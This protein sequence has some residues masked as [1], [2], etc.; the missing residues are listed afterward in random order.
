MGEVV[1]CGGVQVR[2]N[3][4]ADMTVSEQIK[5]IRRMI[6]ANYCKYS[7]WAEKSKDGEAQELLK[8]MCE[9]CPL[10]EL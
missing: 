6:C 2:Q 4:K 9:H 3:N 5:A 1:K 8:T 7:E 10:R